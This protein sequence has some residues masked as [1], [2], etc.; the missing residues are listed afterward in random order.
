[1][2]RNGNRGSGAFASTPVSMNTGYADVFVDPANGNVW[3]VGGGST[4][5]H[6]RMSSDG[7][8]TFGP[9]SAPP[10]T[11]NLSEWALGGGNIYG[12]STVPGGYGAPPEPQGVFVIPLAS[13]GTSTMVPGL[14]PDQMGNDRAVS[15]DPAGNA[16][17]VGQCNQG[18]VLQ[19]VAAGATSITTT[20]TASAAHSFPSYPAV[21]AGPNN[22]AV[23]SYM[24]DATV[25]VTVQT[26]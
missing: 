17:V 16:Y 10:G 7:A 2:Y 12:V 23:V 1:V 13:P 9:D 22:S 19:R 25:Y 26:F 15:A 18:I 8:V 11:G 24:S 3:V 21:V 4:A 6:A 14:T 20:R 5:V